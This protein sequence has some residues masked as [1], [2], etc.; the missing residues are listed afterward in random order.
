MGRSRVIGR[1]V[2]TT[3]E[4]T[5]ACLTPSISSAAVTSTDRTSAWG[6]GERPTAMCNRWAG[7]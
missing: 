3:S 2:P 1:V 7:S 5:R 6:N 4:P